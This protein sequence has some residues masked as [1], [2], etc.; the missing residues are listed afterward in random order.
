M[1][2]ILFKLVLALVI[3]F[4]QLGYAKAEVTL[5]GKVYSF[6]K[7]ELVLERKSGLYKVKLSDILRS[8][9]IEVTA[10]LIGKTIEVVVPIR[11]VTAQAKKKE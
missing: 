7:T 3:L 4:P 2:S 5:T 10:D 1:K 9:P 6:T 8:N 11:R